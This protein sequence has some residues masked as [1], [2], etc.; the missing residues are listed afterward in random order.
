MKLPKG[1]LRHAIYRKRM[2]DISFPC[3]CGVRL[4]VQGFHTSWGVCPNCRQSVH[5]PYEKQG[6][7]RERKD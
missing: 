4:F 2:A 5:V 6:F 3:S 1:G 7:I